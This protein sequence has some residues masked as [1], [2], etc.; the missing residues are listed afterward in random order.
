MSRSAAAGAEQAYADYDE[1]PGRAG[2]AGGA[3]RQKREWAASRQ[4]ERRT[5]NDKALAGRRKERA[6]AGATKAKA[7]ERRLERLGDPGSPGRAGTCACRSQ[8]G[9]RSG[10]VVASLAGAVVD[11][12]A[13]GWARST[14]SCAGA[15]AWP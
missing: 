12:A 10:E 2:P 11:R 4:G 15:T 9:R 1:S 5:D 14:W 8:A 3:A 6:T 7:I 13:S